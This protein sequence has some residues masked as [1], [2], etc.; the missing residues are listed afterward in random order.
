MSDLSHSV[1]QPYKPSSYHPRATWRVYFTNPID[2][3]TFNES[4]VKIKPALKK[5][6]FRIENNSA[7]TASVAIF[8]GSYGLNRQQSCLIIENDSEPSKKYKVTVDRALCDVYEQK[9]IGADTYD[10]AVGPGYDSL[11]K[12][13]TTW[14]LYLIN[15]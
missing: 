7:N 1:D 6:V 9:L 8:G 13:F 10:V 14:Y 11:C 2:M 12:Y 4:M 15:F 3:G 5:A